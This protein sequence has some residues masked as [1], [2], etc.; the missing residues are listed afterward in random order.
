MPIVR[1]ARFFAETTAILL[2]LCACGTMLPKGAHEMPLP[3]A[4]YDQAL[5]AING[6]VAFKTT[7]AELRAEHIDPATNPSITVLTYTDLLARFPAAPAV[8]AGRLDRGIAACLGAGKQCSAYWISIRQVRTRRTGNFWLDL[9]NFHRHTVT[10]G[11]TFRAMILFV[12]DT[13]VY[14]LGSGQPNI[15]EVRSSHNPLGP[16]QGIGEALRPSGL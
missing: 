6:I 2:L 15:D 4:N 8:P 10:T 1:L 12:G 16:L 13:V 3:W 7:R 9:F 11:W 5:A 14:A